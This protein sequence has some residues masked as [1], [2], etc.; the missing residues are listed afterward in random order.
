MAAGINLEDYF[1]TPDFKLPEFHLAELFKE[2]TKVADDVW[3]HA[4]PL[5]TAYYKTAQE[6]WHTYT[7]T[8][9][10]RFESLSSDDQRKFMNS[11][12][13]GA[14]VFLLLT[15]ISRMILTKSLEPYLQQYFQHGHGQGFSFTFNQAKWIFSSSLLFAIWHANS[16]YFFDLG[17]AVDLSLMLGTASALSYMI[18]RQSSCVRVCFA[19]FAVPVLILFPVSITVG[20][21]QNGPYICQAKAFPHLLAVITA[22]TAVYF[23][24]DAPTTPVVKHGQAVSF[25]AAL[26]HELEDIWHGSWRRNI[27]AV[28][29]RFVSS[30]THGPGDLGKRAVEASSKAIR[31]SGERVTDFVAAGR[32]AIQADGRTAIQADGRSAIR[33]AGR[34]AIQADGRSAI[35]V[36]VPVLQ[37]ILKPVYHVFE[38]LCLII[39]GL[40]YRLN[41]FL[42]HTCHLVVDVVTAGLIKVPGL[43]KYLQN[44]KDY[45]HGAGHAAVEQLREPSRGRSEDRSRSKTPTNTDAT[46]KFSRRV[47]RGRSN[48]EDDNMTPPPRSRGRR[49]Y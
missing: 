29:G 26:W 11:G 15:M 25:G 44:E 9:L 8:H 42:Y 4:T 40:F 23:L 20:I 41:K 1:K 49:N 46:P 13:D 38:G 19:F 3:A 36:A 37:S 31:M 2:Y 5:A 24:F 47:S 43:A 33:V 32:S 22:I 14:V 6:T 21:M 27:A 30:V 39:L 16:H 18:Y 45:G 34:A 12:L 48:D 7:E 28:S 35:Q 17:V 10:K